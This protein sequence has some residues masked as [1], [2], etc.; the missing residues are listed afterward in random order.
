MEPERE[1]WVGPFSAPRP[2]QPGKPG[3]GVGVGG[4]PTRPPPAR[5][6]PTPLSHR[7]YTHVNGRWLCVLLIFWGLV[8]AQ[9]FILAERQVLEDWLLGWLVM[10]DID[11][12]VLDQ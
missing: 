12:L 7:H 10:G 11:G 2:R 3:R 8:E 6:R 9:P 4:R 1:G 5:R